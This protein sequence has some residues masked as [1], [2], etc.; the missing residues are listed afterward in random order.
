MWSFGRAETSRRPAELHV[1]PLCVSRLLLQVVPLPYKSTNPYVRAFQS[2]LK[3]QQEC[4]NMAGQTARGMIRD[5]TLPSV[6]A[7]EGLGSKSLG[8]AGAFTNEAVSILSSTSQL[9]QTILDHT[10]A[11]KHKDNP[12]NTEAKSGGSCDED[13]CNNACR[14]RELISVEK[15]DE[16]YWDK[17]RKNNEAAKRSREKRRANDMVLESQVLGLLEENARLRAELLVLKFHFGL[18]KNSSDASILPLSLPHHATLST[19]HECQPHSSPPGLNIQPSTGPNNIHIHPPPQ[20][21]ISCPRKVR[22]LS[23]NCVSELSVST[24]TLSNTGPYSVFLGGRPSGKGR[25]FPRELVGEHQGSNSHIFP[26]ETKESQY[27]NRRDSPEGIRSLPHKLRFKGP[28]GEPSP[29]SDKYSGPPIATVGPNIYDRNLQQVG[30]VR[31]TESVAQWSKEE[32]CGG[33][34]SLS[35]GFYNPVQN[36][37]DTNLSTEDNNLRCQVSCLSQE[38]AQLKKLLTQQLLTRL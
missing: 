16:A 22:P 25:P 23:G 1:H 10:F 29:S 14:K 37:N 35:S 11:L 12:I 19:N 8:E 33:H 31:Q 36:F 18:V 7:T 4:S 34:R 30:W 5:L 6:H 21:T 28:G 17:R 32:P 2:A 27:V 26:V 15:K 3:C 38:V 9:A 20:Q 24:S 13:N